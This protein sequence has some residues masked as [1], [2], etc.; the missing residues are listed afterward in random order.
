MRPLFC[1]LLSAFLCARAAAAEFTV[2]VYNVENL[3]DVDGMALYEDYG[4]NTFNPE[5][6]YTPAQLLTKLRNI[7]RV[8][9]QVNDGAGPEVILFQEVELDRT[10]LDSR[11]DP[12]TLVAPWA[13]VP[14]A[15]MLGAQFS[16]AISD[17][18]AEVLLWKLLEEQGR[19][20]YFVAKPDPWQSETHTAQNNVVFSRFPIRWV[21]QRPLEQARDLLIAGLEVEGH[22]LVV[23][24]NHWKSGASSR[25]TEPTR[26]QNATVVRAELE[27]LLLRNPAADV[28]IA[29]DLNCYYNQAAVY[30]DWRPVGINDVLGSQ[31]NEAALVAG[32][33]PVLYNLWGELPPDERGSEVYRGSWGTLMQM[34]LTRGLYD[35][36]GVQYVDNSFF[37]LAVPGL[38]VEPVWGQ[39]IRWAGLGAGGGFSDHL[40][41]GARFRTVATADPG[42][43][44]DLVH[45]TVEA[46]PPSDRPM[47][48]YAALPAG[49]YPDA[50]MLPGLSEEKRAAAFGRIFDV[51]GVVG[52]GGHA[53]IVEG[54]P[55]GLYLPDHALRQRWQGL[56]EGARVRFYGEFGVYRGQPQ[57]VVQDPTWWP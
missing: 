1:L 34:L 28:I 33:G 8:L 54:V 4:D 23:M 43:F 17:L 48:D 9:A 30:P 53:V 45:P 35:Q 52:A 6:P 41:V 3:F 11:G 50:S 27:A 46:V 7:A 5:A 24:D 32:G 56:A 44:L 20:G 38:N 37:R 25:A 21:R 40:P 12:A 55:Y 57:F 39:P 42:A 49:R 22:E 18:P 13:G 29:G 51:R 10:P 26:H 36:A 2:L 47:V 16:P 19:G 15:E 31:T 14:V